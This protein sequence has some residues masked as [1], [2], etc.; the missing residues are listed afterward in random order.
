MKS[1]NHPRGPALIRKTFMSGC[2]VTRAHS[3]PSS[4]VV[5]DVNTQVFTQGFLGT[6]SWLQQRPLLGPGLWSVTWKK[7]PGQER[8]HHR[9][10]CNGAAADKRGK[11]ESL[12]SN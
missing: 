4:M 2:E 5:P 6:P 12:A 11:A 10:A 9:A 1:A 8:G 7:Q 3:S